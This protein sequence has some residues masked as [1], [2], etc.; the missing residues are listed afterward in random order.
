M[1]CIKC[2][3]TEY[4]SRFCKEHFL[5]YFYKKFKAHLARIKIIARSESVNLKGKNK[6][7]GK[8][9]L[10]S[11]DNLDIKFSP[12]GKELPTYSM[13][14]KAINELECMMTEMKH[15]LPSI[16]EC[17]REEE[18]EAF[19]NLKKMKFEQEQY[20]ILG[21]KLLKE[22]DKLEKRK[23]NIYTSSYK[24]LEKFYKKI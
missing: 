5:K 3:K 20:S 6:E 8:H 10:L 18:I 7:L 22:M 4:C 11:I 23:P 17:Y 13:D 14:Y 19:C 12:Q 21:Q 1:N 15:L 9:L 2:D 24:I 16:L